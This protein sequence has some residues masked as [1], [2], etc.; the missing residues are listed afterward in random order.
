MCVRKSV[1]PSGSLSRGLSEVIAL[2]VALQ[3]VLADKKSKIIISGGNEIIWSCS[4][5]VLGT[6]RGWF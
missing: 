4:E 5:L 1:R 2:L 6:K 3:E